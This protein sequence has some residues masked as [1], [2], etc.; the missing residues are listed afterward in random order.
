M[1][2]FIDCV[3]LIKRSWLRIQR[4]EMVCQIVSRSLKIE[5]F[6]GSWDGCVEEVESAA[7]VRYKRDASR[8]CGPCAVE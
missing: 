5:R 2:H 7:R 4:L 8:V 3:G 6:A 1:A